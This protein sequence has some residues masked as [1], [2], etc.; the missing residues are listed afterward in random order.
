[1]ADPV[2]VFPL[3]NVVWKPEDIIAL[4]CQPTFMSPDDWRPVTFCAITLAESGGDPLALGKVIWA[5]DKPTHLTIDSFGMFQLLQYYQTMVDPFPDVP[6]ITQQA[7]FDPHKAWPHCWKLMNKQRPGWSY[8]FSWWS[9]SKSD[10]PTKPP[11]Y[12]KHLAAAYQGM[13]V[14]RETMELGRGVFG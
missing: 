4:I 2:W 14:Y 7:A 8:N 5:P 9:A 11:P 6:K 12:D 3:G 13:R 10:D 1:M